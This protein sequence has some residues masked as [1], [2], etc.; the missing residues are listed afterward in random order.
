MKPNIFLPALFIICSSFSINFAQSRTV[1]PDSNNKKVNKRPPQTQTSP[2]PQAIEDDDPNTTNIERVEI[3][4]ADPNEEIIGVD[5]K[6]VTIPVKVADRLGRYIGGLTKEDFT[7]DEDKVSQEIAFFSNEEQPFTVALVLDM[8]YSSTFKIN[9]IHSAAIAFIEQLRP[10]D[11]VMVVSFD[12]EV[13]VLTSPTNDRQVLQ[14]AIK[15]TKVA[16]GTSLYEAVDVIFNQQ[17]KRIGGR[18]AIVLF[19]DGVDTTSRSASDFSNK[20]SALEFD[21]LIYPI[22]YD[23]FA[24]VQAIKNK[25]II[26]PPTQPSPI[27]SKN[28]SPFPFPLP[29]GGVGI[30]GSQGTSAEDYRR[31]DEY[32][33]EMAK[34]TGGS[35]YKASTLYNLSAAFSNIAAELRQFYSLGYYPTAEAQEGK[36]RKI[37][38]RVKKSGVT[39][40]ARD[41]YVVGKQAEKNNK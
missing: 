37:K 3:F 8:S 25:P 17:F 41:G 30:P 31:A 36:R 33:E 6:L 20:Q 27:P 11:K 24:D 29:S 35:V 15:S 14:R 13:H 2:T 12:E 16:S 40:Q 7:V 32:L 9:E 19:T 10:K 28:K 18:K 26:I 34:R 22:Q 5:T 38:V 23:T 21:A 39:V 1:S 4:P